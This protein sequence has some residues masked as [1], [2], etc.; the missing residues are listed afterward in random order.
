MQKSIAGSVY[1]IKSPL[2]IIGSTA[3]ASIS[4]TRP[5]GFIRRSISTTRI[6]CRT[7]FSMTALLQ[8]RSSNNWLA[9]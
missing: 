8:D 1:T 3:G 4:S 9:S 5:T 6:R 2:L 7:M